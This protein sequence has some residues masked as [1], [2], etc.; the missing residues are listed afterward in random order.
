LLKTEVEG[1]LHTHGLE[2]IVLHRQP[3]QGKTLIEKFEHHSDVGYAFILLTPDDTA[4]PAEQDAWPDDKRE[5]EQR[6]RQ[7]VILELG[8]FV[9]RLSRARVCCLYKAG[10]KVPGDLSG[11]VYKDVSSGLDSK[12]YDILRE[13]KAAGYTVTF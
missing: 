8:Y 5:K 1:F 11:L 3:D 4:Y 7:N 6:A 9:G 2:P 13:L 10:V 12:A